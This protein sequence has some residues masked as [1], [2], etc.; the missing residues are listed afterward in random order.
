MK[1]KFRCWVALL[2]LGVGLISSC[3]SNKK[4]ETVVE[5]ETPAVATINAP[6]FNP[7]SAYAYIAKQVSFGPRVPN[8]AAHQAC[9]DY[10]ISKLKSVGARVVVQNFQSTAYDGKVLKLRNIVGSFNTGAANRILLAA[11]WDT[12]PFADKDATN[13]TKPNDGANDGASG[14]GVLLEMARVLGTT[15]NNPGIGVDIIFFD[16]EDYGDANGSTEESW[17]LGSQYWAKNKHQNGYNANFG[18]L[19]DMVGANGAKFAQEAYSKQNAPQ[20][21]NNVWKTASQLGFSDYF[22]YTENG[23]ITDDHV[24]M[25]QG[26]VPSIDIIEYDPTSPDGTFGKYHHRHTDNM[27][28]IDKNTLKAVG[29]TVL[30]VLYNQLA[31]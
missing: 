26:G 5:A 8:T 1:N 17:C 2:A 15:R 11:H 4:T 7:D 6:E 22:I 23:A 18:I 13:P 10:L 9:G 21:V 16:G 29:Q 27:A 31:T 12:R 20:V 30:Q 19:L 25:T 24:Y 14:V 28:I 3:D